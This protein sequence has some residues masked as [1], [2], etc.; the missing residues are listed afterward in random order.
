[1]KIQSISLRN[2]RSF[3]PSLVTVELAEMTALIGVNGAG[4]TALLWAL[5]RMFGVVPGQKGLRKSDFHLPPSAGKAA[6]TSISL[7]IELRLSFPEL[8]EE[9]GTSTDAVPPCFKQMLI[10]S[11]QGDPFCRICLEGTWTATNTVDGEGEEKL[12]WITTADQTI[13]DSDKVPFRPHE[14][15]LIHVLYV[16]ASRDPSKEVRSISSS[17][18]GRLLRATEWSEK[19]KADIPALSKKIDVALQGEAGVK[20]IQTQIS[21]SWKKMHDDA[22][23]AEPR[24][25]FGTKTLDEVLTRLDIAFGPSFDD[26]EHLLDRL[27]EGQK[28]LFYFALAVAVFEVERSVVEGQSNTLGI[29]R[30][31]LSPP[32]LTLLAVEEPENHLAPQ[33]LGRIME[34]LLSVASSPGGQVV[35]SSH[36]SSILSRVDPANVRYFRLIDKPA[37]SERF[38]SITSL[39]LPDAKDEAY[40]YV[41]EAV[42]AY[43]ELYFARL[44]ILGEGDSEEVILPRLLRSFDVSLDGQFISVVPLGGRYVNHFWRLLADLKIP[45]V[46]LLDLD[47]ERAGGGWGRI[48]YAC[49]QLLAI[50][51]PRSPLLSLE[52]GKLLSDNDL[53]TM[54]ERTVDDMASWLEELERHNV[55]FSQPLD[56]D[57]M[58][59]EGFESEYK[60]T[61]SPPMG[62]R[63][64]KANDLKYEERIKKAVRAVLGEEGGDGSSYSK[65][66]QAL[67]PWYSYLFLGRGK[68]STHVLA[69]SSIDETDLKAKMP[70]SLERLARRVAKKLQK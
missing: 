68:P 15:G 49:K 63:I 2:F 12:Y 26:A 17:L 53:E 58:M 31:A 1:M 6:P 42:T 10:D 27:S 38:T 59:L 25:Q 39:I 9:A 22:L 8:D 16:P 7:S 47:K 54:H 67:F 40:K 55:F 45:F 44:V 62:P 46:T 18:L 3:G 37:T 19:N 56:L 41:K 61:V 23:Y 33:F 28:S 35:L 69:L 34:L 64:P 29:S 13:E 11:E 51:V 50:G 66:S 24:L 60:A 14:R 70:A 65:S 43:P 52:D 57:F 48:K 20:T 5:S 21:K 30:D 32:A 4:K 36:S